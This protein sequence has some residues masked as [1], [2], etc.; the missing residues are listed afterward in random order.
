MCG[1]NAPKISDALRQ[2]WPL[3]YVF[4]D[5]TGGIRNLRPPIALLMSFDN[6]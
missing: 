2:K 4:S 1:Q 5:A 3:T 6:A